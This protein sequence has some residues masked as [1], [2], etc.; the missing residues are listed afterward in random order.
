MNRS[1]AIVG[2]LLFGMP[3]KLSLGLALAMFHNILV[4]VDGSKHA[5][6]ALGEAID[7]AST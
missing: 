4:C 5:E 3:T 6:R 1:L 2:M 7:L